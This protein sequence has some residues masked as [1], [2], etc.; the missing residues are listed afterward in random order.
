MNGHVHCIR[1]MHKEMVTEA[2]VFW[3]GWWRG[4][5]VVWGWYSGGEGAGA[6][7]RARALCLV[8][9]DMIEWFCWWHDDTPVVHQ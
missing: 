5:V 2:T 9:M 6:G 1:L 7:Y 3:V 8:E 4:A